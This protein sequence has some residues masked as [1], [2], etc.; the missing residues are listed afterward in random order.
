MT[1]DAALAT[2]FEATWPAAEYRDIAGFR[3][4]RS[5]GGGGR[6]GSAVALPD[7]QPQGI[8]KAAAM[9]RDW[10]QPVLFRVPT[11]MPDLAEALGEFGYR[12][13]KPTVILEIPVARLTDR[14]LPPI[15]AINAW[16][17]LAIQHELW[18]AGQIG[19]PRLEAMHRVTLPKQAILGRA[20]DRAAGVAFLAVSGDVAMAH[21]VLVSPT[22][23]RQGLAQWIMRKGAFFAAE[24]GA[25]R[26]ALAVALENQPALALY[27]KLGFTQVAAYDYWSPAPD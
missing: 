5:M 25:N 19:T 1:M 26:L 3:I 11:D 12:A 16:P 8:A 21:A 15:T 2:A 20:E 24:H 18:Q 4:G 13:H 7:W 6:L 27:Q 17:P 9:H 23:R 22:A 10:G 14:P